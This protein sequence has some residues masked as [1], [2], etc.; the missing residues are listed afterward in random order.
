VALAA[1]G[2]GVQA[3]VVVLSPVPRLQALPEPAS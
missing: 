2:F 3:T 1:V